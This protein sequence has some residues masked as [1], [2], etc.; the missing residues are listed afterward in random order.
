MSQGPV[1]AARVGC[2]LELG[3]PF[4]WKDGEMDI[5]LEKAHRNRSP[6]SPVESQVWFGDHFSGIAYKGDAPQFPIE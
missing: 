2:I 6:W 5:L 1:D 4:A 3:L